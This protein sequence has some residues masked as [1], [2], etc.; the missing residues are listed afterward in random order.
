MV[1]VNEFNKMCYEDDQTNR[2]LESLQLFNEI[3]NSH[4]FQK[5]NMF[6]LFTNIKMFQKKIQNESLRNVFSDF[7]GLFIFLKNSFLENSTPVEAL[8]FIRKKF[9][10]VI[11]K[12]QRQVMTVFVDV[13][14]TDAVCNMMKTLI[15]YF[16]GM[17]L[18]YLNDNLFFPKLE[19]EKKTK[20]S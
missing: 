18:D 8:R 20:F 1:N 17:P 4:A 16:D 3:V 14:D 11:R 15:P 9:L 13:A 5:K 10:E 6:L 2:L 12:N 19:E 7:K